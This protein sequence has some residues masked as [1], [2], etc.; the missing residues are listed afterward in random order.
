LNQAPAGR[1]RPRT[2]NGRRPAGV[3]IPIAT[4]FAHMAKAN[5]EGTP[6]EAAEENTTAQWA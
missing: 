3:G 5:A 4:F 2:H 1:H 6:T